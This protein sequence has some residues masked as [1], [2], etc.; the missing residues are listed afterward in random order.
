MFCSL[1]YFDIL[2]MSIIPKVFEAIITKKLS[3]IVSRLIC[4]NL[5]A[6]KP[7]VKGGN[8]HPS[9]NGWVVV[10][11]RW[12]SEPLKNEVEYTS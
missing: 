7:S 2:K 10:V 8:R 12:V 4:E 3:A 11:P 1:F 6:P 9:F 5:V